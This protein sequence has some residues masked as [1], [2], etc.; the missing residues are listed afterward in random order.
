MAH[1]HQPGHVVGSVRVSEHGPGPLLGP[2]GAKEQNLHLLGWLSLGKLSLEYK[3]HAWKQLFNHLEPK[4]QLKPT[5]IM[6][7]SIQYNLGNK[8][9]AAKNS[10]LAESSKV[11]KDRALSCKVQSAAPVCCF[12]LLL[13]CSVPGLLPRDWLSGRRSLSK[14]PSERDFSKG[15]SNKIRD[16]GNK[17]CILCLFTA[18]L[19]S[20]NLIVEMVFPLPGYIIM[21]LQS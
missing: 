8:C 7:H 5:H 20:G 2:K 3:H 18:L 1:H 11:H 10:Y 4:W 21:L 6:I 15:R 9:H 12:S 19:G 16:D 13:R 17:A 14:L